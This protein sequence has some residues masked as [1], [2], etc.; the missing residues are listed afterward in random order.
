MKKQTER[1]PIDDLFARKLGD[2]SLKPSS[3]AFERLQARMGQKKTETKIVFWRNPAIQS[4]MAAA[5]CLLLVCLFGWL[6]WPSG[7]R[8]KPDS[9]QIASST[10]VN[11]QNRPDSQPTGKDN[12]AMS[13]EAG[14]D[15]V[16]PTEPSVE[17]ETIKPEPIEQLAQSQPVSERIK[18]K[19]DH[20]VAPVRRFGSNVENRKSEAVVA[21]TK[22]VENKQKT[23]DLV[24]TTTMPV[25]PT[26]SEPP[27]VATIKP[28]P[29]TERG[30]VVTIA[31]PEALVAARQAA[32]V[33]IEEK[34][35]VALADKQSEKDNK[36]GN[37]WQQVKR[38][39][40]GDVFARGDRSDNEGGLL[41]RAYSGLKHSIEKD[42]SAKE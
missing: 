11:G 5:A 27:V 16:V 36:S 3:D 34:T 37:I 39:K 23:S 18:S 31:E 13:T 35:A 33:S 40:Q 21:Q 29:A 41:G 25:Q 17:Q 30:L 10:P 26:V 1:Q 8:L 15:R 38:F 4:Y 20:V 19:N 42:K 14:N 7:D 12:K 24:A 22:P 28:A 2:M 9:T 6:Y 32:K